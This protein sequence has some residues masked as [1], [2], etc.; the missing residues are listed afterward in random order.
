LRPLLSADR[1]AT[2]LLALLPAVADETAEQL[3]A[4]MLLHAD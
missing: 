2:S 3:D 4:K 1:Y